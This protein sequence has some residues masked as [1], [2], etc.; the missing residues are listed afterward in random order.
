MKTKIKTKV[1]TETIT[2]T[3]VIIGVATLSLAALSAMVILPGTSNS[4]PS[5]LDLNGDKAINALDMDVLISVIFR[6]QPCPQGKRCDVNGD[7]KVDAGDLSKYALEIYKKGYLAV[8]I[9]ELDFNGDKVTNSQDVEQL[10]RVAL[11]LNGCPTGNIC[12][13]NRDGLVD[14]SDVIILNRIALGLE[15]ISKY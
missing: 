4:A 7:G 15:P 11:G 5:S 14:I 9:S 3:L 10:L 8:N 12:D 6:Y 1:E 2:K 13:L